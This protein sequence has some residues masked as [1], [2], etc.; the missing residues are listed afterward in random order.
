MSLENMFGKD[1]L[2]IYKCRTMKR[3][4]LSA[5]LTIYLQAYLLATQL[6][7]SCLKLLINGNLETL[8]V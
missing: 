7:S 4:R 6:S 8:V 1:A 3:S 5:A 2:A